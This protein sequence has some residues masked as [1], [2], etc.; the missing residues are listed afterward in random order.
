MEEIN[1][2]KKIDYEKIQVELDEVVGKATEMQ[3]VD[4]LSFHIV[5]PC[6]VELSS[7]EIANI[8]HVYIDEAKK[9]LPKMNNPWAKEML[10]NKIKQYEN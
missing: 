9:Y 4:F 3:I 7:G 5:N 6:K 1:L 8:R 2:N 10:E